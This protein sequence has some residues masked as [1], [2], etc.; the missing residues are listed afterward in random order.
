MPL[1]EAGV[2]AGASLMGGVLGYFGQKSANAAA[3][4]RMREQNNF[5]QEMWNRQ[6]AYNT[7]YEQRKRYEAA[8]I[9]PYLALG[10]IQSGTAQGVTAPAP[11]PVGNAGAYLGSGVAQAGNAAINAYMQNQLISS[12]VEKNLAEADATRQNTPFIG[13][14]NEADIA[15]TEANTDATRTKTDLDRVNIMVAT[16]SLERLKQM[17][18]LEAKLMQ[19]NAENVT[20]NTSLT[21]LQ[22]VIQNWE[23][24]HIKPLEAQEIKARISQ[25]YAMI[26][27]FV[28]QGRLATATAGLVAKQVVTEMT[29]EYGMHIDNLVKEEDYRNYSVNFWNEMDNKRAQTRYLNEQADKTDNDDTRAWVG[30]VM[31]GV[32][33]AASFAVPAARGMSAARA[34]ARAGSYGLGGAA[35]PK[36]RSMMQPS[37]TFLPSY[38]SF[39]NKK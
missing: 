25:A 5:T 2:T 23:F 31:D 6:N 32:G 24:K 3:L 9:N 34:A 8:G 26:G 30:L 4:E 37:G 11:A 15:A 21:K 36:A 16:A 14:R 35:V 29:K 10:N 28:A 22:E 33:Q 7:P 20:A 19:A 17:T 38:K 13:R 39:G 18:P 27:Y 12:E 1:I